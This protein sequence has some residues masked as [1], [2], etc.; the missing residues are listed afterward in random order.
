MKT[1]ISPNFLAALAFPAAMAFALADEPSRPSIQG[2]IAPTVHAAASAAAAT[3]ATPAPLSI[4]VGEL[5]KMARSGVG[6]DV[7]LTFV[8]SAGT[9]NLGADQIIYLRDLGVT[10]EV[11]TAIIRHDVDIRASGQDTPPAIRID[12]PPLPIVRQTHAAASKPTPSVPDS[13]IPPPSNTPGEGIVAPDFELALGQEPDFDSCAFTTPPTPPE[14]ARLTP[15]REP[16]P[17]KL[18][19]PIV[20]YRATTPSPNLVVIRRFP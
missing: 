14:R 16:Y 17:V 2:D 6:P 4:W 15:V 8:D 3:T 18:N 13:I 11:I 5:V 1:R 20:M 7:M 12:A 9:F 10:S 19:D